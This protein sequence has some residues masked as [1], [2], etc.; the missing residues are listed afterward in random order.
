MEEAKIA[1]NEL[2]KIIK[3]L[4]EA[5]EEPWTE[6]ESLEVFLDKI[7]A[8]VN[9]LEILL[10]VV[11]NKIYEARYHRVEGKPPL[12]SDEELLHIRAGIP[13]TRN[14]V[15]FAIQVSAKTAQA[16]RDADVRFYEQHGRNV[17]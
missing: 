11:V 8:F 10:D 1:F 5:V 2:K 7:K 6:E 15:E 17:R 4:R 13:G 14:V 12:L 16:H 3:E 9:K